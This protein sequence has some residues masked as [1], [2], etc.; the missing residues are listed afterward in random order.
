MTHI[1]GYRLVRTIMEC[2]IVIYVV[3][4]LNAVLLGRSDYGRSILCMK[5]RPLSGCPKRAAF[6]V[7]RCYILIE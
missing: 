3:L 7:M 2:K 5:V 6:S 1:C 4:T